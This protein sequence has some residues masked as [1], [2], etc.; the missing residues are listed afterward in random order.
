MD[1]NDKQF[2]IAYNDLVGAFFRFINTVNPA[3]TPEAQ[4]SLICNSLK[5]LLDTLGS[6]PCFVGSEETVV[7]MVDNSAE[8]IQVFQHSDSIQPENISVSV[9]GNNVQDLQPIGYEEKRVA[10]QPVLTEHDDY[11][12]IVRSLKKVDPQ[13]DSI[14][15]YEYP[16]IIEFKDEEGIFTLNPKLAPDD[17]FPTDLVKITGNIKDNNYRLLNAGRIVKVPGAWAVR[18]PLEIAEV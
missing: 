6:N 16:F 13:N 3:P 12:F 10:P 15:I 17:L 5:S 7:N 8:N 1:T 14:D 9:N 11:R 4:V 2:Q 18:S